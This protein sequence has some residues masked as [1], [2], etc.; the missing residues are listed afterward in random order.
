MPSVDAIIQYGDLSDIE[1]VEEPD[2]LVQALTITPTREKET[3]KGETQAIELIRFTNPLL[4]FS[5]NAIPTERAGLANQH[6]GTLVEHLANYE[7]QCYDFD[8]AEGIMVYE[9]PSMMYSLQEPGECDFDVVHY[10]FVGGAFAML[11]DDGDPVAWA[12]GGGVDF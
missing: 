12:D 7:A 9:D 2:L 11:W 3:W 1:L 8:P 5:F 6:P 10:P 4:T